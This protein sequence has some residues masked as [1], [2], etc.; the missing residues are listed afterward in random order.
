MIL[1]SI[2]GGFRDSMI[3]PRLT[4]VRGIVA[5]SRGFAVLASEMV[6]AHS[7]HSNKKIGAN[8]VFSTDHQVCECV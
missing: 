3:M 2:G 7:V 6:Q 8:K 5:P 1:V 4:S